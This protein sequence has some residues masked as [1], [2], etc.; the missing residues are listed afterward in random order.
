MKYLVSLISFAGGMTTVH[1][2][3]SGHF[4]WAF[5]AACATGLVASVTRR[6]A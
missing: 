4:G 3:L 6:W 5:T 2:D 1:L